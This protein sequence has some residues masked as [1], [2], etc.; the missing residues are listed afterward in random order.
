MANDNRCVFLY[1]AYNV[2]F[3]H[4]LTNIRIYIDSQNYSGDQ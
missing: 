3:V 2:I 4:Y 1:V